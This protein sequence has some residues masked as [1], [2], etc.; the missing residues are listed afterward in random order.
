LIE[1]S[2]HVIFD[3]ITYDRLELVDFVKSFINKCCIVNYADWQKSTNGKQSYE[4]P[5]GYNVVDTK[6]LNGKIPTDYPEIKKL[7][8]LF[9]IPI[10]ENHVLISHYDVGFRLDPHTDHACQASIMFPILPEDAGAE[11]V[12][13][14]VDGEYGPATAFDKYIDSID[15]KVRY[16]TTHPTAFTT[17]V[18][19]SVERVQEERIYLKFMLFDTTFEE[20]KD[21]C[22]QG[23]LF[24][25][26]K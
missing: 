24:D 10:Q 5:K 7:V 17:Q 15:Y 12:F 4:I 26:T 20:L 16:S 21:L 1:F 14:D 8:D 13:H 9:K 25:N 2:K 3:E 18:P 6:L 22:R 19:H 11:L 23:K